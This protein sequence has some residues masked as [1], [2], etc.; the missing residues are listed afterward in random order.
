MPILSPTP[1]YG[2][3]S[4]FQVGK[5]PQVF[6][7]VAQIFGMGAIGG[8]GAKLLSKMGW[9]EGTGLG[10]K[11]DGIQD[12]L[13]QRK[14]R[15]KLGVGAENRPFED[16]WWEKMMESSYGA[17]EKIV[18]DKYLFEACEGRRCRPHGT[19]KLARLDAHEKKSATTCDDLKNGKAVEKSQESKVG[20]RIIAGRIQKA[21]KAKKPGKRSKGHAEGISKKGK[22]RR[23]ASSKESKSNENVTSAKQ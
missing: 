9:T 16:A 3:T 6:I 14:R 20:G 15:N 2:G 8:I 7:S 21:R 23:Q 19:A 4:G 12:A 11:R 13:V 1:G 22:R 10:R 17:A 5:A 18:D